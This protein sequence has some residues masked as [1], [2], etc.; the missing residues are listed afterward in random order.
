MSYI[1]R[2]PEKIWNNSNYLALLKKNNLQSQSSKLSLNFKLYI[3]QNN[4]LLATK[5]SIGSVI[6]MEKEIDEEIHHAPVQFI[7]RK[8]Q[9]S[10]KNDSVASGEMLSIMDTV[11][12][13]NHLFRGRPFTTADF[14][15]TFLSA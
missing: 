5:Y 3:K 12:K 13:Y 9:G 14:S 4:G 2:S 8:L 10:E 15:T 7:S 6:C 1:T 11:E